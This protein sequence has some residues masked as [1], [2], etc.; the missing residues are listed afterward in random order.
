[1]TNQPNNQMGSGQFAGQSTNQMGSNQMPNGQMQN[2]QNG[3]NYRNPEMN[4]NWGQ[5]GDN[6]NSNGALQGGRNQTG[7]NG[8]ES[9]PWTLWILGVLALAGSLAANL[10]LG[11]SY[12][13]ARQKY[14][15][16]V[17]KTAETFRRVKSV[18]A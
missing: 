5:S 9:Q 17:R 1:S 7:P 18:A 3:S 8:L 11:A 4:S 10:Y 16:L 14:Q 6:R 13:D 15:S 12:L 2:G